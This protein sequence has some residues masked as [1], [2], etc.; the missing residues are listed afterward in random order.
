MGLSVL[1]YFH[2]NFTNR[3]NLSCPLSI[4]LPTAAASGSLQHGVRKNFSVS[5]TDKG[6]N[7]CVPLVIVQATTQHHSTTAPQHHRHHNTHNTTTPQ[8]HN[9]TTSQHQSTN[10]TTAPQH[11]NTTTPQHHN[12]TTP[13]HHNTTPPHHKMQHCS[14]ICFIHGLS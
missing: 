1:I 4:P 5:A 11:H 2:E 12:T 14:L 13:Q 9:T 10:S 7:K 8:H 6:C 3:L